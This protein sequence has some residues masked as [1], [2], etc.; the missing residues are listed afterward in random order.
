MRVVIDKLGAK[1]ILPVNRQEMPSFKISEMPS[2]TFESVACLLLGVFGLKRAR[3]RRNSSSRNKSFYCTKLIKKSF[4]CLS[5]FYI[6]LLSLVRFIVFSNTEDW[7]PDKADNERQRDVSC[8][9]RK[10][11][12]ACQT[13]KNKVMLSLLSLLR[14][15]FV[16]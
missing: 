14:L 2:V 6:L 1:A 12:F 15:S 8:F 5:C 10:V 4:C 3:R 16:L 11:F 7:A 9:Q 13:E